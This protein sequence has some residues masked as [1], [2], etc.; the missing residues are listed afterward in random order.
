MLAFDIETTG[1][2]KTKHSITVVALYGTVQGPDGPETVDAVLNFAR[3]GIDP[4]RT[5]LLAIL[6]QADVLCAFNGVRFDIPFIMHYLKVPQEQ[7]S[8]WVMKLYD[9]F[10][11]NKLLYDKTMSLNRLL[12]QF[13]MATKCG[14]G[15]D[16]VRMAEMKDWKGL[17]L[18]CRQDTVLTHQ[19]AGKILEQRL[20]SHITSIHGP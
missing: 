17:S 18:Y 11:E 2:D 9:P 12:G 10:E 6:D 14:T 13:G 4:L 8:S 1:L 16:A 19:V 15:S 3:D 5:T 20:S 7:C